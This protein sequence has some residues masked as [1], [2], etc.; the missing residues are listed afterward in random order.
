MSMKI[1]QAGS[2]KPLVI[3][4]LDTSEAGKRQIDASQKSQSE[5][6]KDSAAATPE[7]INKAAA[8]VNQTMEVLSHSLRFRVDDKTERVQVQIV[9]IQNDQII[10]EI[11]PDQM[12][13]LAAKIKETAT[14]FNKMVGFLVDEFI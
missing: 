5:P 9:D 11:P 6:Q 4:G 13:D 14:M 1:E 7:T 2:T 8:E 12:L 3:P 10:K